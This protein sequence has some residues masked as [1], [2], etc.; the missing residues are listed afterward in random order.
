MSAL[1]CQYDEDGDLQPCAYHSAKFKHGQLN[2]SVGEKELLA[3]LSAMG[4]WRCYLAAKP[5]EWWTDHANL[6]YLPSKETLTPQQ[7]R[8]L[9]F[10]AEYNFT[11][12]HIPGL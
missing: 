12:R 6:Q 3:G 7:T 2:Y 5:F 9:Q 8:W 11:I 4:V 1:L 10:M